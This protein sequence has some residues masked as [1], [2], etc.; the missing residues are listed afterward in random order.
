MVKETTG[1][2]E[3]VKI[4]SDTIRMMHQA[5]KESLFTNLL[6][7]FDFVPAFNVWVSLDFVPAFNV[8]VSLDFVPALNVWVR[9]DLFQPLMCGLV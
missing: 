3:E 1:P 4:T 8:W 2:F 7:G 6:M 9:L 5:K